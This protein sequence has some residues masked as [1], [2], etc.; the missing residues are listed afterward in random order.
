MDI[1]KKYYEY[2]HIHDMVANIVSQ[3]YKDNWRPDYIVGL[4]RG[5]L[6]PAV[7]MSN[8]YHIPMETLKVSL[9]DSD[10][11]SESNLWMS[12]DAYNGKNILILDDINDTGATLDWIINDW[13][14]SC[15]PSDAHWSNVWGNNVKI[16]V[17][18]DNLSSNFSR[19]VDYSAKEINKAE[20]D[21]WIVYPWER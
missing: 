13:Q 4:T 17:L 19:T 3:M 11:E 5:G 6:I 8:V 2:I 14:S 9:R 7:V 21:V 16:A 18:V 15:H 20:K 1:N 12:E 10:T